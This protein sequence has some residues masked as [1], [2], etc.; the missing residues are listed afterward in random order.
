M[1]KPLKLHPDRLLP[2]DPATRDLARELYASVAGQP[3]LAPHGHTDAR[4]FADNG[5]FGNADVDP[6]EA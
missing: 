1:T 6:R 4:W 2:A 5:F 3:F